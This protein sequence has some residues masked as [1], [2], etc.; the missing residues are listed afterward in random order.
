MGAKL[1]LLFA[2][3]L[4]GVNGRYLRQ[5]TCS[6]D[7]IQVE[8]K[9]SLSG[10]KTCQSCVGSAVCCNNKSDGDYGVCQNSGADCPN[11]ENFICNGGNCPNGITCEYVNKKCGQFCWGVTKCTGSSCPSGYV[12]GMFCK[13][14]G[15]SKN[16]KVCCKK[17]VVTP[18][19]DCQV[20]PWSD[21]TDCGVDGIQTRNRKVVKDAINGGE[22][23]SLVEA[24]ACPVDCKLSPWS[25]WTS[26][27]NNM[28]S[29]S[30]VVQIPARNG[31]QECTTP[32][33]ETQSC[34]GC[35]PIL[36]E[37]E[38]T[39]DL[40]STTNTT[41]CTLPGEKLTVEIPNR[42]GMKKAIVRVNSKA[43]GY[44]K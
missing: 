20:S 25:G 44:I 42:R 3:L 37:F 24:Q 15:A 14:D 2:V 43:V 11:G 18:V 8:N 7:D 41:V 40:T 33:Q 21:W 13:Q 28:Q 29:R 1:F 39:L 35:G 19:V 4:T 16:F 9:C 30:R 34:I 5:D 27:T 26:C 12:N 36:I 10:F 23:A 17:Q 6:A 32:L 22:C 38:C 31:G